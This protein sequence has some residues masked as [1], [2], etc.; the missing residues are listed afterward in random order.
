MWRFLSALALFSNISLCAFAQLP[1]D[2]PL[3]ENETIQ[4]TAESVF[5]NFI[6]NKALN[7]FD[8]PNKE[9]AIAEI[10]K[11]KLY[12]M[13]MALLKQFFTI[14]QLDETAKYFPYNVITI[15]PN[16]KAYITLEAFKNEV[17][18]YQVYT[19]DKDYN[20][21]SE[22]TLAQSNTKDKNPFNSQWNSDNSI[23]INT[24][25]NTQIITFSKE[26]KL[27]KGDMASKVVCNAQG[28]F[29]KPEIIAQKGLTINKKSVEN[30]EDLP[31]EIYFTGHLLKTVEWSDKFGKHL[32]IISYANT[33]NEASTEV[34][35][36]PITLYFY[37]YAQKPTDKKYEITHQSKINVKPCSA[38]VKDYFASEEI[39]YFNDMDNNEIL[40]VFIPY[41]M[42]CRSDNT[43]E[44][45]MQLLLWEGHRDF[46]QLI[47]VD[48]K[49]KKPIYTFNSSWQRLVEPIRK[50]AM[51]MISHCA[52]NTKI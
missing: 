42:S 34:T 51:E 47:N 21:V 49:N 48:V 40:E 6:E 4:L 43:A 28:I 23:T 33:K 45:S 50:H 37:H 20:F 52:E 15:S 44:I 19:F 3:D 46:I 14:P 8:L 26:E 7:T 2:A 35:N 39:F 29:S 38:N 5:A 25:T 13:D 10:K 41:F 11:R 27:L 17:W 24:I 12:A 1:A 31:K 9:I 18:R 22:F 36:V 16:I 30:K 32:A